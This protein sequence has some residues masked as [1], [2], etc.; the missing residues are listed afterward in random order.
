MNIIQCDKCN[1]YFELQSDAMERLEQVR[2]AGSSSIY[3]RCPY[4]KQRTVFNRFSKIFSDS[5]LLYRDKV[6]SDVE[7]QRG[8]L[9]NIYEQ[10]IESGNRTVTLNNECYTLYSLSSL[11]KTI[12]IDGS[13]L[14]QIYQLKGY[15]KSLKSVGE[16]SRKDYDTLN[17]ALS[18]GEGDGCIPFITSNDLEA[19]VYAFFLDGAYIKDLGVTLNNLMRNAF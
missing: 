15:S 14:P 11:F 12:D 16:I 2:R 10:F 17:D 18:I 19:Y 9:P 7:I 1:R 5:S 4:C 3:L 13:L 6:L 8:L